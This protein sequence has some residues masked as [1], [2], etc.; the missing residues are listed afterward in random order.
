M[1]FA[2]KFN[3]LMY[4]LF[5]MVSEKCFGTLNNQIIGAIAFIGDLVLTTELPKML[6]H[7]VGHTRA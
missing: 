1:L 5:L 6:R 3:I 4:K 2:V 7:L